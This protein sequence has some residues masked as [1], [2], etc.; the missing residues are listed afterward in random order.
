MTLLFLDFDGVL[1]PIFPL[2]DMTD[3]E[4]Q[5]F[6]SRPAFEQALRKLDHYEIVISSSWRK[7]KSL[8]EIRALFSEDVAGHIIGATPVL[9][10]G[11]EPGGRQDEIEA[12]MKENK[13]EGERWIALDDYPFLFKPGAVV[14]ACHDR[15]HDRETALFEEALL[16]ISAF[17]ARYPVPTPFKSSATYRA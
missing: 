6:S 1:H 10:N 13:R 14:V 17:A 3:E 16:D 9:E 8:D 7:N 11:N 2:P 15:F 4:N 12:W 5:H